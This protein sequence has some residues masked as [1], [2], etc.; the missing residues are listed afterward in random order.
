MICG[1]TLFGANPV[2]GQSMEDHYFGSINSKV[3]EFMAALD[4]ELY[5]YGIPAKQSIMKWLLINLN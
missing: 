2:K 1:R 5:R 4:E 3:A